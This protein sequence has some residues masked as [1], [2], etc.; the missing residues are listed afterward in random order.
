MENETYVVDDEARF[1]ASRMVL[2]KWKFFTPEQAA[3]FLENP[4]RL[5]EW[6]E[7]YIEDFFTALA[8]NN[9]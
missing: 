3:W 1:I 5:D 7:D 2:S 8:L 4:S 6:P 9:S